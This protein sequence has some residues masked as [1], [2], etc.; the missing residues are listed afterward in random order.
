MCVVV[1]DKSDIEWKHLE[2]QATCFL[3]SGDVH[4]T[5]R[6]VCSVEVPGA[7]WESMET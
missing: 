5:K 3:V 2:T 6:C 4:I 1:V 7:T